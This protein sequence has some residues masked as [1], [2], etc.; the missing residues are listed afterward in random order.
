MER[1]RG[2]LIY[3]RREA[4]ALGILGLFI[5]LTAFTYGLHLGKRVSLPASAPAS[6]HADHAPV[7]T[8]PDEIPN[9]QELTEQGKAVPAASDEALDEALKEEVA[10]TGVRLEV[11]RQ[12]ELPSRSRSAAAGA[13]RIRH[14]SAAEGKAKY[15]LQVGSYPVES[16]ARKTLRQL[17][18]HEL[19]AVL[20][21]VEIEGK[22]RWYRV[23]VGSFATKD[24][25]EKVGHKYRTQKLVSTFLVVDSTTH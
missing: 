9:R 14:G 12:V 15:T 7:Q 21:P 22:G 10:H 25:A 17:Q 3:D 23:Y 16:E 1:K 6:T 24:E 20:K 4:W 19:D 2:L 18:A 13:T 11:P 8:I 5:V